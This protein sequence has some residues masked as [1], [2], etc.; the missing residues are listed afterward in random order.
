VLY[1]AER[2]IGWFLVALLVALSLLVLI[3]SIPWPV[4][5]GYRELLGLLGS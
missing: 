3:D 5:P 1:Y 2:I 4:E